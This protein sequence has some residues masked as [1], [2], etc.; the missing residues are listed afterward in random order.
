MDLPL[1]IA[2][3]GT[4]LL[5]VATPGP[6]VAF[7]TAQALKHGPRA[8]VIAVAGD[9]LGS[10][11]HIIVAVS[12]LTALVALSAQVL[13]LLQILGGLFLLYLAWQALRAAPRTDAP[14]T[15]PAN[16]LTFWAGFF[17]CVTNPKAIVFFM[18]LFPAFISPD[19]SMLVQS[20]VLGAIFIALDAASILAYALLTLHA[21]RRSTGRWLRPD[22]L[23]AFGLGGVGLAMIV[24]GVRALP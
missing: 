13:P 9:A 19:H 10:A 12:S 17:A 24:K 1:L 7:A 8:A 14:A 11:V 23:S 21:V 5:F 22:R 20:L 16:R 3:L 6:S 2:F 15:P 4:T 18:A